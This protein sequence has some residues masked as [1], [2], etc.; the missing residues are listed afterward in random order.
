MSGVKTALEARSRP[1]PSPDL[2]AALARFDARV[3]EPRSYGVNDCCVAVADLLLAAHGRDPM[4]R[5][6][7]RYRTARGYLRVMR[8]E[9]CKTIEH[10]LGRAAADAGFEACDPDDPAGPADFDM[11]AIIIEHDG[12]ALI[13]PAFF[14]S[15]YWH[16]MTPDGSTARR[17][18]VRAW[19]SR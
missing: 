13:L 19:R 11:G 4:A 16:A 9:G 7:N 14:H 12:D 2:R 18:A 1:H 6:R 15:G 5:F 10:A 8:K 17:E 3:G